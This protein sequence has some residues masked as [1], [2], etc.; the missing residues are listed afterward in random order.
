MSMMRTQKKKVKTPTDYVVQHLLDLEQDYANLYED[1]KRL[2]GQL[3]YL[4]DFQDNVLKLAEKY[5]KIKK[6]TTDGDPYAIMDY[7]WESREPELFHFIR[8]NLK[9]EMKDEQIH[10]DS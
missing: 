7:V 1:K 8:C 10:K 9:L 2:E 4:H 6:S 3:R 5:F